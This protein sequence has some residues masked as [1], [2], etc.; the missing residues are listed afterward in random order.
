MLYQITQDNMH[1]IIN[2]HR[3]VIPLPYDKPVL[4][5]VEGMPF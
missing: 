4:S 2:Y 5:E 3:P 1:T